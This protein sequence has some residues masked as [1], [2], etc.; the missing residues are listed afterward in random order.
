MTSENGFSIGQRIRQQRERLNWSQERLAESVGA[1][2]M[3]VRRWEHDTVLPQPYYREQ[4]CRV[5]NVTSEMLFGSQ[6]AEVDMLAPLSSG[7]IWQV[8]HL[9][10]P[11]FTGREEILQRMH[12]ILSHEKTATLTQSYALSGLG[13]IGKTQTAIEYAYRYAP[14]YAAVLWVGAETYE[15]LVSSFV[16]LADMLNLPEKQEQ[17]QKRVVS[18]V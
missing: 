17:E 11:F 14:E 8:P 13:G 10:N 12:T 5:F 18:A 6:E 1:T 16:T 3:S 9:R 2:K 7:G 4:L 15:S